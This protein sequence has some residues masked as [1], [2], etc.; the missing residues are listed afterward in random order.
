MMSLG[1][2]GIISVFANIAPDVVAKMVKHCLDGDFKKGSQILLKHFDLIGKLF[3]EVSPIP[4]KTALNL[5]GM[6]VG[7][8]RMPLCE[9]EPENLEKLKKSLTSVGL[10]K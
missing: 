6:N 9:M 5:M 8:P 10:I 7:E 4:V 1:G 3:I 2:K